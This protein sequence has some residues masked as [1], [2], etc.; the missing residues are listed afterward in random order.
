MKKIIVK[1]ALCMGL[2]TSIATISGVAVNAEENMNDEIIT[3]TVDENNE[4]SSGHVID[5]GTQIFNPENSGGMQTRAWPYPFGK[6][7]G[8]GTWCYGKLFNSNQAASQYYHRSMKHSATLTYGGAYKKS[9]QSATKYATALG[10]YKSGMNAYYWDNK[11][12][13]SVGYYA[14][15]G[16][17]F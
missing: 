5:D 8:G 10:S 3:D 13:E 17:D 2:S 15:G 6:D 16:R 9:V 11:P 7:I 4:P 12:K 14:G 1:I